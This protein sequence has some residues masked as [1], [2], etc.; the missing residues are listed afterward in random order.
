MENHTYPIAYSE[1]LT[2]CFATG[3]IPIYYGSELIGDVFN[4]DGIIILN[5]DF[6][7]EDLTSELY[8]SKMNAIKD[9]YDRAVNMPIAEDYL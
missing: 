4:S 6:N 9:N 3:T 1:K 7:N 5:N 8:Y 2:D